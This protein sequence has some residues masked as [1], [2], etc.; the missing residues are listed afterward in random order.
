MS[1]LRQ[2]NFRLKIGRGLDPNVTIVFSLQNVKCYT[3][4]KIIFAYSKYC[5]PFIQMK[6]SCELLG[7]LLSSVIESGAKDSETEEEEE[8]VE[9]DDESQ[10][11]KIV[12]SII[13]STRSILFSR[14]ANSSRSLDFRRSV[15]LR[16]WKW[17]KVL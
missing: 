3:F 9:V 7:V 11:S 8:M 17:V 16:K 4:L 1:R 6:L 10:N 12:S 5:P 2:T 14:S 15:G 13:A